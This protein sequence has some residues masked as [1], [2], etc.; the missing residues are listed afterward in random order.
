VPE[1]N[2]ALLALYRKNLAAIR[3]WTKTHAHGKPGI[4]VPET[5]R[6]NGNGV[7]YESDRFRP[8]AIV[9]HSCD[10]DWTSE[11]NARTLSSGAEIGLWIWRT[12]QQ[13]RD[14]AF[15]EANYPLMAESARFLLAYQKP[16]SD[17]MLHTSPSNAHETQS[18]VR[19]PAT[20][21]A[22]IQSSSATIAAGRECIA[23]ATWRAGSNQRSH[24]RRRCQ[25]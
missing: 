6:F 21:I 10:L 5:M 25:S 11:A 23:M 2:E 16:D 18:D 15:L 4:C 9:T 17:G 24:A 12:W 3:D 1:L 14:R 13:T 7:E 20:D 8:F 19:D 22:A